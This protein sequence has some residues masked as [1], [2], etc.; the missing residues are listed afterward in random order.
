MVHGDY[1]YVA[2]LSEGAAFLRGKE[3]GRTGIVSAAVEP[4]EDSP[5]LAVEGRS[6]HIKPEAVLGHL[7]VLELEAEVIVGRVSAPP[8]VLALHCLGAIGLGLQHGIPSGGILRRHEA[9]GLGVRNTLEGVDSAVV[10]SHYT[11]GC[12]PDYAVIS[13]GK[14]AFAA[15]GS[16]ALVAGAAA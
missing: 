16:A 11:A 6:P 8:H 5:F 14:R 1:H 9:L 12:G 3:Y 15:V 10:V 7:L 13:G 2:F 4:Y